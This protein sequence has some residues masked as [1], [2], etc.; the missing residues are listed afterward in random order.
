[1]KV[2]PVEPKQKIVVPST[3]SGFSTDVTPWK[4]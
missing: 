3:G 4:A 1:V 2:F